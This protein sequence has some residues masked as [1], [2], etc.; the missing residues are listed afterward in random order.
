MTRSFA[1]LTDE[2]Q[3]M[4]DRDVA[5]YIKPFL[6][7]DIA[8]RR[9]MSDDRVLIKYDGLDA[10][11]G[12]E[13]DYFYWI[14]TTALWVVMYNPRHDRGGYMYVPT[15]ETRSFDGWR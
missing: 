2:A 10:I 4:W 5:P 8:I 13:R 1:D 11:D 14:E 12:D 7:L 6:A 15:R 3:A 9:P